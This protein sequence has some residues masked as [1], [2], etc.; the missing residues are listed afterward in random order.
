[1]QGAGNNGELSLLVGCYGD[2]GLYRATRAAAGVWRTERV[3]AGA[4]NVSFAAWSPRHRKL[5]AVREEDEGAIDVIAPG[6]GWR[7]V[8]SVPTTGSKPCHCALD[9]SERFLAVANYESGE[10]A[11]FS[12]DGDGIPQT[13]PWRHVGFG[14]GPDPERQD[15]PHAHWVG[16]SPDQ[17]WVVQTDL[18][19]DAVRAFPFDPQRGIS[20]GS[21]QALEAPAGSGPRWMHFGIAG[22]DACLVSELDSTVSLQSW[23]DGALVERQRHSTRDQGASGPNLAGHVAVN[24]AGD[25]IYVTNR[26]D[27]TISLFAAGDGGLELLST[28]ASGGSSP[29]YLLLLEE[30][31]MIIVGHEKQGPVVI[32][33]TAG[34]VPRR[35]EQLD[36]EKVAWIGLDEGGLAN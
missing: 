12:L 10:V 22:A 27:D 5:Y 16:F 17:R 1:M 36:I 2:D 24:Q 4:R 19:A 20:G 14:S 33:D 9:K 34:A 30:H 26:G 29:R 3:A 15:G 28:V 7:V 6:Q 31:D 8:A 25:R 23:A 21:R 18:G 11:M 32:F 13:D 35:A